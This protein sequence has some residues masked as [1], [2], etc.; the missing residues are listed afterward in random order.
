VT[1]NT[2]IIIVECIIFYGKMRRFGVFASTIAAAALL[3][4]CVSASPQLSFGAPSSQDNEDYDD[5]SVRAGLLAEELGRDPVTGQLSGELTDEEQSPDAKPKS[6]QGG[7][8]CC[9]ASSRSACPGGQGGGSGS[10]VD[11]IVPRGGENKKSDANDPRSGGDYED[12]DISVRIVTDFDYEDTNDNIQRCPAGT[13]RCCY[14]SRSALSQVR[15]QCRSIGNEEQWGQFCS[16]P[17][18]RD[19][20]ADGFQCGERFPVETSGLRKGQAK[21][22][23][24]PWTC[25]VLNGNNDFLGTCAI[26]PNNRNNDISRGTDRVITAA[27]KLSSVQA[28]DEIKVRIIEYDASGFNNPET[29][30]HQEFTVTKFRVHPQFQSKRLSH[31]VAI[32]FLSQNIALTSTKAVNAACLPRCANMF[33]YQFRNGTGTRC[34]VAGWGKDK[35]GGNFQFIQKK[36]DVPIQPNRIICENALRD[37]FRR[38]GLSSRGLRLS[39]S[40]ICAGGEKGKDACEGDGGAPLVCQA[41]TGRW[42]VVGL[43][44]WGVGCAEPDVPG[45]YANVHNML[46][47][48]LGNP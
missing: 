12:D 47:F 21:P 26:I 25:L 41:D 39:E 33:D 10:F 24:F 3:I 11:A 32:L 7:D 48:I 9:C 27:H 2:L 6:N 28:N 18:V 30:S 19:T 22:Y 14:R 36:I 15:N 43:V 37:A 23:E 34:W 40:E 4:S 17:N 44:T 16:D 13:Q 42:Y 45:V 31:D 1:Y 29:E 46:S 38:Q 8:F 5:I 20:T 35:L